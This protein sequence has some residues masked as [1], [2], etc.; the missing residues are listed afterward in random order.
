MRFLKRNRLFLLLMLVALCSCSGGRHWK[1]KIEMPR[2]KS[3]ELEKFRELI[4]TDF[5]I[6]KE[7]SD[8]DINKEMLEYLVFE[9][10]KNSDI[11]VSTRDLELADEDIFNN[12]EFW[13]AIPTE[14]DSTILLTGSVEYKSEIRKALVDEEKRQF[15]D[16]FP[17]DTGLEQRQF[18]TLFFHLYLIDAKTGETLYT[19]NFKET[20]NY[21]NPNQTAYFA[22]FDLLQI[23]KTKLFRAFLG[24]DQIQ[25]RY[26]ITK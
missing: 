19:R 8:M 4:I 1:L 25:E 10:G 14:S 11:L 24:D 20:K 12:K 18:F 22:F 13:M 2:S 16:P 9:F 15:E 7:R 5:F 21:I 23:V 26:L 6:K 3:F 17:R